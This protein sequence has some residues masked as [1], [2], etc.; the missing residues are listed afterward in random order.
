[1]D[2]AAHLQPWLACARLRPRPDWQVKEGHDSTVRPKMLVF[3]FDGGRKYIDEW[4]ADGKPSLTRAQMR[5]VQS[6]KI[7]AAVVVPPVLLLIDYGSGETMMS[8]LQRRFQGW[9][10]HFCALDSADV[11]KAYSGGWRPDPPD[12]SPKRASKRG[13]G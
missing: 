2:G 8:P 4:A 5:R 7:L 12:P 9:W 3:E 11:A 13:V 1:V 6:W 10:R